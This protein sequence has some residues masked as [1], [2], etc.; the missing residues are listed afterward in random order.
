[1]Q[2]PGISQGAMEKLLQH[3]FPGNV[4]E[5]ENVLERAVTLSHGQIIDTADIQLRESKRAPQTH[6]ANHSLPSRI[7]NLE[8]QA[9]LDAL[10]KTR[11]NKTQAAKTLGMTLR[12][13][14]YRI[15][16]LNIKEEL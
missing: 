9:I 13:L 6:A 10:K 3:D 14:R 8:K 1:M 7:D 11:F 12:Q 4:R 2:Q 5:L 16:K 15:E